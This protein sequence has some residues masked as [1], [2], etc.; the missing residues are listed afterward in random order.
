M[1][2]TQILLEMRNAVKYFPGTKAVDGVDF[3]CNRGEIHCLVGENGAGKS[4]LM[5]LLA[6]I[7]QPT[8]GAIEIKGT[9]V[10]LRD[11]AEARRY[12]IGVVY[13]ELS[14]LPE[15]S[16]AEN[17]SMGM[18]PK[19]KS[20]RI[21]WNELNRRAKEIMQLVH[22][23]LDPG[24]LIK[25]LPVAV[26]QMIEISKVLS[27]NPDIII[28]DEPTAS[29][30]R[31]EVNLLF[32]IIRNL[33]EK[34]KGII[35]ISHRMEEVFELADRVTVMKDGKRVTSE[36]I[37]AFTEES[38]ISKMVGR[39]LKEIFPPKH[40]VDSQGK[41]VFSVNLQ[42][43]QGS[44]PIGFTAREGEV[45]GVGGL[46]GQGQIKMLES[47]F[48]LRKVK[49]L[50][51]EIHGKPCEIG[52]QHDAIRNS[53]ALIPENRIEEGVF[54]S[55][56]VSENLSVVT[57]PDRAKRGVVNAKKETAD[58]R[59]MVNELSVKIA[60]PLQS[61]SSLSGGNMQ[62]LV[63]GKWLMADPSVVILLEPTKG[64]DV[65]TKQHI[66]SL[67]RNLAEKNVICILYTSDMLELI[68][69]SDRVL[70]LNSDTITADL[71]GSEITEEHIMKAAVTVPQ[72][73]EARHA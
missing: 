12:G 13:Q 67:I 66:Y 72:E 64:V 65:G 48:G 34:G 36:P 61:A 63:L 73:L 62:K 46:Q 29:L 27:Q 60:T 57:M 38:L 16:I 3:S 26:R 47:I 56:S 5:K 55:M 51:V 53:M 70:V 69:M 21:D 15:C 22:L 44:R 1:Q 2:N 4:T 11:Y 8:S 14:L 9:P 33:K 43:S 40:Q 24:E 68:G 30:S 45:L 10:V 20:G 58:V 37:S 28:F 7:Y 41:V 49:D 52:S 42:Y 59:A 71:S 54:L 17:L 23:E 50:Q 32:S 39:E 31:D 19:K 6:G 18:W 35:Y 25:G